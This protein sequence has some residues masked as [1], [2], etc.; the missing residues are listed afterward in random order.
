MFVCTG[1]NQKSENR[2]F[3]HLSFV[4]Y[5]WQVRGTKFGMNI[6]NEKLLDAAKFQAYSFYHL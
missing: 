6:Y 4:K 2:N 1:F 3:P 5:L